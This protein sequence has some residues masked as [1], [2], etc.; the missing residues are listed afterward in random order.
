ME[1]DLRVRA[2]G[3]V[4]RHSRSASITRMS[5]ADI[6]RARERRVPHNPLTA[7]IF[8]GP[9]TGVRWHD[10]D[11]TGRHGDILVR[12]Y[13]PE[14]LEGDL[15]V[16][17][18]LHGG[19][20]VLGNLDGYDWICSSVAAGVGA[21]V[22]SVDYRLAP[23]DPY[24][25]AREDCYDAVA[26]VAAHAAELG[27]DPGRL[28][29]MGDSAGGNLTAVTTLMARDAGGPAI[30]A[31]V[32]VYPGVDATMSSRSIVTRADAPVLSAADIRVFLDHYLVGGGDP[33]DPLVSPL[34]ADD[35]AGLPPALVLTAEHDPLHDEGRRYAERLA[36]AG[37]ST[38]HTDYAGMVHG[39][40][41]IPG[42]CRSAPQA[43]AEICAVLTDV[44]AGSPLAPRRTPV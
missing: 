13:R 16:V 32:L 11:A 25:A 6:A 37:V 27:A 21:V 22:V 42:F 34:L 29:V 24:P 4:L 1:L 20:F 23:E 41:S 36:E 43:L 15:P 26:W 7:A 30:A 17:V 8:G 40:L 39:F 35:L 10:R 14:W 33:R 2:L 9:V 12:V 44:F 3:F 19:G 38:R 5:A 28:A 18:N 31:Q